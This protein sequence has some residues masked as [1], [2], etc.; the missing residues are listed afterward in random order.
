ML[1][2]CD[3]EMAR[4]W[5]RET[6]QHVGVPQPHDFPVLAVAFSPDG[7]TVVSGGGRLKPL[8]AGEGEV[9]LW[10]VATGKLLVGPL[11]LDTLIHSVAFRPDGQ[12]V[13]TGS[14]D[15]KIR[16]WD[17]GHLRPLREWK[18]PV[19]LMALAFS[20][21]GRLLM[22]GGGQD[23]RKL[24][25]NSDPP[26]RPVLGRADTGNPSGRG[27]AWLDDVSTGRP[28]AAVME[29]SGPVESVAFSPDGQTIATGTRDGWVRLWDAEGHPLC[30]P[31]M[32]SG[33]VYCMVFHPDGR[34]LAACGDNGPVGIWEVPTGHLLGTLWG[35]H[36]PDRTVAFSPDG[37]IIAAAGRD[38]WRP[39]LELRHA[40]A[41]RRAHGA[42]HGGH[43]VR[44]Q[45]RWQQLADGLR[46]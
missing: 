29:H 5:D 16:I 27:L 3:D 35:H 18:R 46:R 41:H 39:A 6:G 38:G 17:V 30:P 8:G 11:V 40:P 13:A 26:T 31:R 25:G 36:Q 32:Q 9:R 19:P 4:L 24:P 28:I 34:Y 7:K 21:D 15:G 43:D 23:G 44:V 10:D 22:T 42:W 37:R 45:S 2:G 12:S 14:R 20:S 33:H 1:T